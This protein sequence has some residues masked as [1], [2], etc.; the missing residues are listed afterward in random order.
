MGLL[1]KLKEKF[2]Q[3]DIREIEGDSKFLFEKNR[4]GPY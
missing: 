4:K 3:A 2:Y 1:K